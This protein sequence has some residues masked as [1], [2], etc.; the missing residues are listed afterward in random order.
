MANSNKPHR[1]DLLRESER[2]TLQEF[3][4]AGGL[5]RSIVVELVE[6]A[7]L[8]PEESEHVAE[9]WSFSVLD[10]HRA[11]RALRLR[12]DLALD[13]QGLSLSLDLLEEVERLREQVRRLE[14]Q[15]RTFER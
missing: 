7:I 9:S 14:E 1:G 13:L 10:L 4:D 11:Q 15:L 12:R 2:L 6:H 8:V 5:E 3:C